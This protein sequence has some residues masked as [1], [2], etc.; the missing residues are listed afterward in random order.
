M[1]ETLTTADAQAQA[2]ADV[3]SLRAA[4]TGGKIEP[5]H[6]AETADRVR[7]RLVTLQARSGLFDKIAISEWTEQLTC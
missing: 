1:A 6:L 2:I 5:T 7:A 4:M 3:R